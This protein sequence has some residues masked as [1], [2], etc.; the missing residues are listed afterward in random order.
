MICI[1]RGTLISDF[2]TL[3]LLT[4]SE[5]LCKE[6]QYCLLLAFFVVSHRRALDT[7]S[8]LQRVRI[9]YIVRWPGSHDAGLSWGTMTR[10][11]QCWL[12]PHTWKPGSLVSN[13]G[14]L[15]ITGKLLSPSMHWFPC[16]CAYMCIVCACACCRA[17]GRLM[18]D[19]TRGC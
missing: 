4:P 7:S 13:Y 5:W 3:R 17:A 6:C 1:S 2:P 9:W 11:V 10:H 12:W 14:F 16:V 18:C 15:E 19:I 8:K